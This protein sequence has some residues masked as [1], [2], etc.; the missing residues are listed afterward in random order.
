MTAKVLGI[1]GSHRVGNTDAM[2]VSAME[3]AASQGVDTET[4][5]LRHLR[6]GVCGLCDD[7]CNHTGVC[8][9]D[10]GMQALHGK[11]RQAH[12]LILA[13]PIYFRS[14]SAQTK[15]MI[16]RCQT[17]WATKYL[18]HRA[19]ADVPVP[20]P[21]A[22]IA[23]SNQGKPQEYPGALTTVKSLFATLD[24]TYAGELL[25]GGL[26]WAGQVKRHP[27]YL[28]Q[29]YDLGARLAS[30]AMASGAGM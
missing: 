18:L 25:I 7:H 27:E 24:I 4:V 15:L 14:V 3:G 23:V 11:L 1:G 8:P 19:V 9:L 6:I 26:D 28:Q 5:L 10:D 2:L 30:L 20:R 16:D 13:S 12:G 21:G 22:F 29:A 17:L